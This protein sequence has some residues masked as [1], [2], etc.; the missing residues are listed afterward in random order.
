MKRDFE[1]AVEDHERYW[2][3]NDA[4]FRAVYQKVESYE[5]FRDIVKASHLKPLDKSDKIK[6]KFQQ[7]WNTL[8]LKT[9]KDQPSTTEILK[10][11]RK[12]MKIPET[13]NEFLV[14]WRRLKD[15]SQEQCR[16]LSAI[17]TTKLSEFFKVEVGHGLLGQIITILHL[18]KTDFKTED[19]LAI[20][21]VLSESQR[22]TLTLSFFSSTEKEICQKLFGELK[23]D[24]TDSNNSNLLET[25]QKLEKKY[26]E[27]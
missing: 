23:E 27:I 16:L 2:R 24:L 14:E 22:F 10:K 15:K 21:E 12:E 6:E 17:N 18:H 3:E 1:K 8:A 19:I 20:L 4:K 26:S 11:T 25:L 9:E 7:P 13:N 5:E